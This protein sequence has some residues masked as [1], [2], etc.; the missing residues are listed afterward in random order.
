M[1]HEAEI[2]EARDTIN[3]LTQLRESIVGVIDSNRS[4][5]RDAGYGSLVE[6]AE[7]VAQRLAEEISRTRSWINANEG[8]PE[9]PSPPIGSPGQSRPA[10]PS[11]KGD[12]D[13]DGKVS[14]RD[15]E[16]AN[17]I[18]LGEVQFTS[19]ADVTG[20]GSV[21]SRDALLIA[22]YAK[23]DLDTFPVD[24][25]ED[26]AP[27]EPEPPE[28]PPTQGQPAPASGLGDLDGDGRVTKRDAEIAVD[29]AQGK[30]ARDPS[31][32][33]NGDGEIDSVDAL[34]IAQYAEGRI[35]SFPA[36]DTGS[37]DGGSSGGSGTGG[38]GDN[39]GGE[40]PTDTPAGKTEPK[41]E[42][43][44][45]IGTFGDRVITSGFETYSISVSG[46]IVGA[47]DSGVGTSTA[48]GKVYSPGGYDVV[49]FT[50]EITSSN[51]GPNL[52][53]R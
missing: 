9:D 20:D 6:E 22:N 15:A 27:P 50:G 41:T 47:S 2:Q 4:L 12:V 10:P 16:L 49:R 28:D 21:T 39:V 1:A 46:E 17:K 3:T 42:K 43:S 34:K 38:G 18:P 29:M 44:I 23:G 7:G 30:V 52:T 48:S 51:M 45:K 13:G 14:E 53:I 31:A 8:H 25:P 11:G 26:P 33:V 40:D 24:E 35:N 37:N 32:D 5:L 36:D 19:A